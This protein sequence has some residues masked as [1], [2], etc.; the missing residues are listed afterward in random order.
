MAKKNNNEDLKK[1]E[2]FFQDV[3]Y[4]RENV[5]GFDSLYKIVL[6]FVFILFVMILFG[7]YAKPQEKNKVQHT[8]TLPANAFSYKELLENRIKD[9]NSYIV[10]VES[11]GVRSRLECTIK[12]NDVFGIAESETSTEK[13]VIKNGEYYT[14]KFDEETKVEDYLYEEDILNL[15]TLI[16]TLENNQSLKTVDEKIVNYK[17]DIIINNIAYEIN[18][19]V[20]NKEIT[21]IDVK[22]ENSKY[23]IVFK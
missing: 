20:E 5:P 2:K 8:T 22:N 3:K 21:N 18:T 7:I 11:N 9:G 13:F 6:W 19:K 16:K 17:Y 1:V 12:E 15:V 4:K 14:V 10:N 23:T